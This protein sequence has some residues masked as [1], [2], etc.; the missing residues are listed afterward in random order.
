MLPIIR[1]TMMMI[2]MMMIA[3]IEVEQARNHSQI[4]RI[5]IQQI[6]ESVNMV[7]DEYFKIP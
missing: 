5:P 6:N 2:M 1:I 3:P 7:L 4:W